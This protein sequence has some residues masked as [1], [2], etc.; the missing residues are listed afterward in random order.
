M[1]QAI[2]ERLITYRLH[3][4]LSLRQLGTQLGLSFSTLA[5]IERGHGE[6]SPHTRL[7]LERWMNPEGEH[8]KCNCRVCAAPREHP[9]RVLEVRIEILEQ[10]VMRLQE[11]LA[12][13]LR[14]TNMHES[15]GFVHPS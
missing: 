3:Q 14:I 7:M 9:Y 11:G 4:G 1:A 8:P 6:P 5:R 2:R 12:R 15:I 10:Q 13:A